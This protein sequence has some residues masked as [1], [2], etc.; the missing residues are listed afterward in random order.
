M[1]A[2][3]KVSLHIPY[4]PQHGNFLCYKNYIATETRKTPIKYYNMTIMMTI[5]IPL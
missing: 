4:M 2:D 3:S 5:F 1:R